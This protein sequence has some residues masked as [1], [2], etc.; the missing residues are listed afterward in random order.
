MGCFFNLKTSSLILRSTEIVCMHWAE[1]HCQVEQM[2]HLAC[3]GLLW[4]VWLSESEWLRAQMQ[5]LF[6]RQDWVVF[7]SLTQFFG[8]QMTFFGIDSVLQVAGKFPA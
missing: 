1:L 5:F 2:M 7:Q 3:K 6:W 4:T 8:T